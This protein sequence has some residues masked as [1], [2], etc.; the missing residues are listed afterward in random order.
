LTWAM[1]ST[2]YLRV[3]EFSRD[4]IEDLTQHLKVGDVVEAMITNV[5]RKTRSIKFVDQG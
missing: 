2:G 4:R 1:T 3:S 5:D